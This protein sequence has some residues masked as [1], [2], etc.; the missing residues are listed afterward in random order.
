M[1]NL[2][3]LAVT[4]LMCAAAQAVL[5]HNLVRPM[6]VTTVLPVFEAQSHGTSAATFSLT[7]LPSNTKVMYTEIEYFNSTDCSGSAVAATVLDSGSFTIPDDGSFSLTGAAVYNLATTQTGGA[8]DSVQCI[9][10]MLCNSTTCG[11]QS[12][13]R[14]L[15][16]GGSCPTFANL[17]C[18][19]GTCSYSGSASTA[20]YG[21]SGNLCTGHL[22]IGDS[23]G[24]GKVASLTRLGET[25]NLVAQSS[26]SSTSIA[27][28]PVTT[29]VGLYP[30]VNNSAGNNAAADG[31]GNTVDIV[32]A[33]L[34]AT[35]A[36]LC[37]ISTTSGYS[38]WF[39][40]AKEQLAD[41]Y[42]NRVAI[43]NFDSSTTGYWSSTEYSAGLPA[44]AWA[45]RF[46][47]GTQF[48]S[49]K[50]VNAKYVRCTRSITPN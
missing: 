29:A 30:G 32:D 48:G 43:G 35:A 36:N 41:L 18:S 34:G 50:V 27:W 28:A 46:S 42:T 38:D 23:L 2:R 49:Q 26:D 8:Q 11:D 33:N 14:A 44:Y 20:S 24:G 12:G 47:D 6:T 13:D 37:A 10:V 25:S 39:L 5:A 21:T 16:C 15:A 9:Q 40:P 1:V 7:G 3:R 17:T 4:A 31:A 45:H 22:A 19:S